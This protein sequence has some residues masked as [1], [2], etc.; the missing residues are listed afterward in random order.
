[1]VNGNGIDENFQERLR[2]AES[3][4]RE[5]QRLEPLAS[6]A[7]QLRQQKALAQKEEE[8]RRAKDESLAQAKHAA[9]IAADKQVRVPELLGHA[10]R[11][12]IELYTLL[13]DIDSSRRQALEALAVAD[14][15][16]YDIELEEGEE[17]ERSL[18]RDTRGLAYALAARH[19]D[20]KIKQMLED[21]DPE[22]AMLRGCNLDE[23]LYRD[24]ANFV[25]R[26]AVPKE[27]PPQ[28]IISQPT[29]QAPEPQAKPAPASIPVPPFPPQPTPEE[30]ANGTNRP[31]ES[32]GSD[33][34]RV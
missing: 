24:V 1:M 9:Q 26:H 25:V 11:A 4:E 6:E 33:Q 16:D 13:K 31:S 5:M 32:S 22:F 8:R 10:A 21:L 20:I 17:H 7:P 30:Y 23:P 19:G 18:D 28:P 3:A 15:V 12:V 2:Q 34:F 29:A 27:A 14:R